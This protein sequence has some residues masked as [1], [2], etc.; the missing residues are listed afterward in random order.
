MSSIEGPATSARAKELAG[1]ILSDSSLA[2]LPGNLKRE[3]ALELLTGLWGDLP[4]FSNLVAPEVSVVKKASVGTGIVPIFRHP[5]TNE[6]CAVVQRPGTHYL[7]ERYPAEKETPFYMIAGGFINLAS[8]PGIENVLSGNP[9]RGE[10]PAE[11]ALRELA[12]ELV[13]ERGEPLLTP[14]FERFL[15]MDA[16]TLSFPNGERRV[17]IGYAVE[18]NREETDRILSHVDRLNRD[19]EYRRT[20]RKHTVNPDSG[21]PEVCRADIVPL[22]E[23]VDD[24]TAL[25]HTDQRSL[26]RRID[27]YLGRLSS[28][29]TTI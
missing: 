14:E 25:L 17:V 22:S 2:S 16:L 11:G 26:F 20:C 6:W 4:S 9:A 7:S 5:E 1:D 3:L 23:L 19:Q 24:S 29:G 8:S 28:C 18:L 27:D 12:E 21:E 15:P 10:H 13:G